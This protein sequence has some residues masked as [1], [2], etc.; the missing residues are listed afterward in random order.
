MRGLTNLG[1]GQ[2]IFSINGGSEDANDYFM[3]KCT[4]NMIIS[5]GISW[6]KCGGVVLFNENMGR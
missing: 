3:G 4:S 2:I 6:L 1:E 5:R